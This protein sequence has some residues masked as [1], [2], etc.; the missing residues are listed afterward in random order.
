M[1]VWLIIAVTSCVRVL[2]VPNASPGTY[3]TFAEA[4]RNWANSQNLY[5]EQDNFHVYRYSPAITL[6]F[7][8]LS[9]VPDDLGNALWRLLNAV[10]YAWGLARWS[11]IALV[12]HVG[13]PQRAWMFLL[14]VP[15]SV[16]SLV[17]AQSN[18]LLI[19]LLLLAVA[20]ATE[21][22]WNW[23]SACMATAILL[24]LYPV[25]VALLFILL[26]PRQ[27]TP[28]FLVAMAAGLALPFCFKGANYV[29]H[30]YAGWFHLLN[31]DNDRSN[32]GLEFWYR[33]LRLLAKVWFTPINAAAYRA[34]QLGIGAV[35]GLIGIAGHFQ[36]WPR[37]QL[38]MTVFGLGCCWM[39]VLGPAT[40]ANTYIV[41]AP[42]LA[43]TVLD[44][45]LERRDVV[46]RACVSASFLLFTAAQVA[47]W[48][49]GV[50]RFHALG[51]HPFAGLLLFGSLLADSAQRLFTARRLRPCI[52]EDAQPQPAPRAA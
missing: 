24:K 29:L 16:S 52:P 43:W 21:D 9:L 32:W 33:D 4:G 12:R 1:I 49:P 7:A 50:R 45:W 27:F 26:F 44:A 25:A 5:P 40:E 30:Q 23:A 31:G 18:A 8:L 17:N 22:R 6:L 15:L 51:P 36:Q 11:R 42:V 19:G 48:F 3:P 20:A 41:L 46:Y 47:I 38:L 35:I 10:V 28:R 2:F 13:P 34:F 37:R 14:V 39:T